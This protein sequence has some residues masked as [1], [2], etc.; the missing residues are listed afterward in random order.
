MINKIQES[1]DLYTEILNKVK[2]IY[3]NNQEEDIYEEVDNAL[4]GEL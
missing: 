3:L 1:E 4:L 2:D